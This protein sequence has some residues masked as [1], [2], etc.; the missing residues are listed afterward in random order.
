LIFKLIEK[1]IK[2]S[3]HNQQHQLESC[4]DGAPKTRVDTYRGSGFRVSN[5]ESRNSAS[6]T[7]QFN[8]AGS[9]ESLRS[10]NKSLTGK[11]MNP[12][13]NGKNGH[14]SAEI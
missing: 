10:M 11:I 9:A 3:F 4:V 14:S 2:N 13:L 8:F 1:N 6:H 7:E 5:H 12:N